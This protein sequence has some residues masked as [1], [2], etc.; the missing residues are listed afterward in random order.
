M[1]ENGQFEEQK[2]KVRLKGDF[3]ITDKNQDEP[4]GCGCLTKL[5]L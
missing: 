2:V 3:P 4:A 5:H 1:K